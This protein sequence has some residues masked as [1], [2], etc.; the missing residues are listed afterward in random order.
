MKTAHSVQEIYK[1]ALALQGLNHRNIIKL[2][3]AF[4]LKTNVVL[5]MEYAGGGDLMGY[6]NTEGSLK[7]LEARTI[8][9]QMMDAV[10]YCHHRGIIHRDLKLDNLLFSDK[11]DRQIKVEIYSLYIICIYF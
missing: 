5:I 2:H 8:F 7:E 4:I 6:L 9:S 3:H 10:G 1:E 11:E